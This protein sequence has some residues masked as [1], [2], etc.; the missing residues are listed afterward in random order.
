MTTRFALP[1]AS[2]L[3]CSL[4]FGF[5]EDQNP[6]EKTINIEGRP[7]DIQKSKSVLVALLK[8]EDPKDRTT[9]LNV[10]RRDLELLTDDHGNLDEALR[11][12]LASCYNRLP[13]FPSGTRIS[14]T[15][16][17]EITGSDKVFAFCVLLRCGGEEGLAAI[18]SALNGDD[19]LMKEIAEKLRVLADGDLFLAKN[20]TETSGGMPPVKRASEEALTDLANRTARAIIGPTSEEKKAALKDIKAR[21]K[22]LRTTE[23]RNIR[24]FLVSIL[25]AQVIVEKNPSVLADIVESVAVIDEKQ[26]ALQYLNTLIENPK[27]P[28]FLKSHARFLGVSIEQGVFR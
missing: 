7:W 27:T 12:S 26:A 20:H 28:L 1:V 5:G 16:V 23:N 8:S 25:K 4:S 17:L 10:L 24:D 9:A 3:V 13:P 19:P 2:I 6:R 21:R 15:N 22:E 14:K 18:K 11:K